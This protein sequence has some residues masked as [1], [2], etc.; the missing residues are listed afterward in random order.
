LTVPLHHSYS[1]WYFSPF[2]ITPLY[3][4]YFISTTE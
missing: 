3:I 2:F 1:C 4:S